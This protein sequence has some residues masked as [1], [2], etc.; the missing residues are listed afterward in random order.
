[1]R[2][3]ISLLSLGK[4]TTEQY[5]F[6]AERCVQEPLINL[7]AMKMESLTNHFLSGFLEHL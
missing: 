3:H 5:V 7:N 1:M 2:D 6:Q 4:A